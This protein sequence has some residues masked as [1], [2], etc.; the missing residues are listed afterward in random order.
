MFTRLLFFRVLPSAN[1]QAPERIFTQ[2]TRFCARMCLFGVRKQKFNIYTRNSRKTAIL[3]PLLTGFKNFSAE[4]R[5]T[6]GLLPCKLPLIV[7]VAPGLKVGPGR[8]GRRPGSIFPFHTR[9][10]HIC[11]NSSA[12]RAAYFPF[13]GCRAFCLAAGAPHWSPIVVLLIDKL[14]IHLTREFSQR[15]VQRCVIDDVKAATFY[16]RRSINAKYEHQTVFYHYVMIGDANGWSPAAGV[17][18]GCC[19][20]S[21]YSTAQSVCTDMLTSFCCNSTETVRGSSLS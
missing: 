7:V 21:L 18:N 4:N 16:C 8:Q 9:P 11:I 14:R 19:D 6:M 15:C 17:R 20:N 1:N 5:F 13:A 10:D 2:T 3:G 12:H